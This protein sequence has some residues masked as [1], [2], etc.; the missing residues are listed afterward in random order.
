MYFPCDMSVESNFA[1]DLIFLIRE[2]SEKNRF[3]FLLSSKSKMA[4]K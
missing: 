2:Y 4:A 3:P 1:F